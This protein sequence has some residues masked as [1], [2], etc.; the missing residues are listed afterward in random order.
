ML[1]S[2]VMR[3]D[4]K[5]LQGEKEYSKVKIAYFDLNSPLWVELMKQIERNN[6]HTDKAKS[7]ALETKPV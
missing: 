7:P 6:E 1:L 3:D 5:R 2:I 4:F